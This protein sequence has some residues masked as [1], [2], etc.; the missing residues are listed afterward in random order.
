LI[1]ARE[2]PGADWSGEHDHD[3]HR[4]NQIAALAVAADAVKYKPVAAIVGMSEDGTKKAQDYGSE[5][6]RSWRRVLAP[7]WMPEGV[8]SAEARVDYDDGSAFL[9]RLCEGGLAR[10]V[11]NAIKRFDWHSTVTVRFVDGDGK[12]GW[13]RGERTITVNSAYV[14]RFIRQGSRVVATGPNPVAPKAVSLDKIV[15]LA[16]P[17]NQRQSCN[18]TA[19][20]GHPLMS[21]GATRQARFA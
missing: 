3:G 20:R 6:H 4:A 17:A 8:A 13:S 21:A 15:I 14:R 18:R 2:S 5:I 9:I 1:E 19:I 10:E 7:L 11:E 12:A 16:F